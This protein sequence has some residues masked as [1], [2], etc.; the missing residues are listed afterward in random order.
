MGVVTYEQANLLLLD[1]QTRLQTAFADLSAAL[2]YQQPH[3][4]ILADASIPDVRD[5]TLNGLLAQAFRTRP[6]VIGL[7]DDLSAASKAAVAEERARLPK[8]NFLGSF[9]RTPTGDPQVRETYAAAGFDVEL[10]LMT[11]GRLSARA[12]ICSGQA[13]RR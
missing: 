4:F 8:V 6:D 10:P 11:G 7:R 12:R 5:Q 13:G 9:G 3:T 1:A 2:G